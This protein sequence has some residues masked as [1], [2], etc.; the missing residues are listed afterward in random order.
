MVGVSLGGECL[1]VSMG[2]RSPTH[3]SMLTALC[4]FITENTVPERLM[5]TDPDLQFQS[6]SG[7]IGHR[8]RCRIAQDLRS[9]I[10]TSLDDHHVFDYWLG[11]YLTIPLRMQ[12]NKPRPFFLQDSKRVSLRKL[13]AHNGLGGRLDPPVEGLNRRTSEGSPS[14]DGGVVSSILNG[15]SYEDDEEYMDEE[16]ES[17]PY[18]LQAPHRVASLHV[19]E[20]V[21]EL[22]NAVATGSVTLRRVEGAKLAF[23][24]TAI[25]VD[26]EAFQFPAQ[27]QF[28]GPLLCDRR[29]ISKNDFQVVGL[30]LMDYG[31]H[32]VARAFVSVLVE[33]GYFYPCD[34]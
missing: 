8:A 20:D 34:L 30:D 11:R 22:L 24:E 27:C 1:T 25:F 21:N 9:H 6:S 12:L 17:S 16:E 28:L 33:A 19:Y 4:H 5:Y 31:D 13:F 18:F 14:S 2:F 3:R 7:F 15:E 10:L 29:V 32:N 26:G 23:M